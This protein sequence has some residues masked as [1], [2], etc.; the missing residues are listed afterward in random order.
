[1]ACHLQIDVDPVPVADPAFPLVQI[2]IL[3]VI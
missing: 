2:R 3:I 1:M